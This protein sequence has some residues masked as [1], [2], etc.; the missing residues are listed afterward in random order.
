MELNKASEYYTRRKDE[1]SLEAQQVGW[2][3]ELAQQSRFKQFLRLLDLKSDFSINDLGCGFG[4]FY[5]FIAD[6]GFENFDYNGYDLNEAMIQ[7]CKSSFEEVSNAKFTLVKDAEEMGP[8][9][10]TIASGIFSLKFDRTEE[11][12]LNQVL[13]TIHKMNDKSK[14]GFSFNSLTK[15][16]D[17]EFMREELY[18]ADPCLFFD[19]CKLNFSKNV[20]LLHDYNQ[21]D[22]TIIVRKS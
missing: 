11:E 15:Y 20:A 5:N 17:K 14:H 16:S 13:A 2:K 10:Y 22:F 9:D 6:N 7:H 1:F 3:D 12:W 21:Y 19:Y 4:H 8:A 18:Y